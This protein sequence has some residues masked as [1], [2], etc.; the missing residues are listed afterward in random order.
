MKLPVRLPIKRGDDVRLLWMSAAFILAAGYYAITHHYESSITLSM[1]R[2]QAY[3]DQTVSNRKLIA[4]SAH[5]GHVREQLRA[6]LSGILISERRPLLTATLLRDLDALSRRHGVSILAVVPSAHGAVPAAPPGPAPTISTAPSEVEP[7]SSEPIEVNA[8]GRFSDLLRFVAEL[9]R[10]HVLVK[11]DHA[12]F[13]LANGQ[14]G[15]DARPMLDARIHVAMYHLAA[16]NVIGD[17]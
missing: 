10:Q 12:E 6:N 13:A 9:P 7:L 14:H 4:Q 2:S 15:D 5:I 16:T 8:R 11:V 1:D 3:Y 17:I